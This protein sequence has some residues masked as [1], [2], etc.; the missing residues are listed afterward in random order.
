MLYTYFYSLSL[1]ALLLGLSRLISYFIDSY[2]LRLYMHYSRRALSVHFT[3]T[4]AYVFVLLITLSSII[5]CIFYFSFCFINFLYFLFAKG[6]PRHNK[7]SIN[8]SLP[9]S[10]S[11]SLSLSLLLSPSPLLPKFYSAIINSSRRRMKQSCIPAEDW[12]LRIL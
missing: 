10:L 2:I 5:V 7:R 4:D 11:L 8:Q 6:T 9:L 1:R 12:G 3:V